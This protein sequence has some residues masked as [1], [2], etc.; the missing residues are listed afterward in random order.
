MPQMDGYVQQ[1]D[2]NLTRFAMENSIE[3]QWDLPPITT[4]Q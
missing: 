1:Q 2:V 4:F 3:N